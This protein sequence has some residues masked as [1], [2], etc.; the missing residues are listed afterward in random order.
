[1]AV[2]LVGFYDHQGGYINNVVSD[3]TYQRG[4][5]GS[6]SAYSRAPTNR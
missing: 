2:R 4:V 5:P 1:M 6:K 3:N